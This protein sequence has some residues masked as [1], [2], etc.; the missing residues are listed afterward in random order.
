[1]KPERLQDT[2]KSKELSEIVKETSLNRDKVTDSLFPEMAVSQNPREF[3]IKACNLSQID[4]PKPG[5]ALA[6]YVYKLQRS[7][8]FANEDRYDGCDGKLGPIT[9]NAI[10]KK[11]PVLSPASRREAKE[12]A[13]AAREYLVQNQGLPEPP[14]PSEPSHAN[15]VAEKA[16][17][18]PISPDKTITIGDS[19]TYQFARSFYRGT[20]KYA[21]YTDT[22]FKSGRSIVTM[23]KMLEKKCEP[24]AA[25][26]IGA[27]ANDIY[28]KSVD[29]L[30]SE[31]LK[32]IELVTR[33]NPKAKIVLLTLHGDN[34]KGWRNSPKTIA[35]IEELNNR[36]RKIARENSNVKLIEIR[37]EIID[38]ESQGKKIL[39][40]DQLHY[41]TAGSKAVAAMI[42]DYLSTGQHKKLTDYV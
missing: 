8:N 31:F 20:D 17:E 1:M 25:Y 36:L 4:P 9:F 7:L 28:Y 18:G 39:A 16:S 34:Y 26:T 33:A 2:P 40:P 38:A 5:E 15:G 29:V 21:K 27:A 30:E 12:E 19:L 37:Q 11:F 23:R 22:Y 41:S 3:V 13:K 42:G 24:A 35:K 6:S 10:I 32:I 14:K